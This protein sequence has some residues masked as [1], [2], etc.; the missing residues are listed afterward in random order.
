MGACLTT[1]WGLERI[2][3]CFKLIIIDGETEYPVNMIQ[4]MFKLQLF[5]YEMSDFFF[6]KIILKQV[7]ICTQ[8]RPTFGH[9]ST[10]YTDQRM[11]LV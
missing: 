5:F 1:S 7:D 11:L 9:V 6:K 3:V 8:K 2:F 4:S 10:F